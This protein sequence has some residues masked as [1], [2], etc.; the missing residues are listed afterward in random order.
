MNP[1]EMT[2][3][4]LLQAMAAGHIPP[5]S[6]SQTIPMKP[7]VI[8]S[9]QVTFEVQADQRHLNPLGGVHGGFAA[10]V[11]DTVTGCA[12]HSALEAGIGYGTIDLNIKMCRPVPQNQPL[13][14]I[15]KLINM[16]KNLAISEGEIVD[17]DGKLYAHATATCMILR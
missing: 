8:E 17:E 6:I 5:A 7:T 11:L 9:G 16:S 15:G 13:T 2:G 14:A 1:K 12:V 10:T 3:L 4:Q